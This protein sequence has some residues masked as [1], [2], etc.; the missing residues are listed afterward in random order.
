MVPKDQIVNDMDLLKRHWIPKR[1]RPLTLRA[2]D[3]AL[4]QDI[5]KVMIGL[6]YRRRHGSRPFY[7]DMLHR[8][9][10]GNFTFETEEVWC[11]E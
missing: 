10:P 5:A 4:H 7:V 9:Q 8:A 1:R 6:G 11:L 3:L 2:E